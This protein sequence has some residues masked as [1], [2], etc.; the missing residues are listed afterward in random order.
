MKR[1]FKLAL[2]SVAVAIFGLAACTEDP[3]NGGGGGDDIITNPIKD[4]SLSVKINSVSING[5][6]GAIVTE[7]LNEVAYVV[8]PTAEAKEYTAE[9]LFEQGT[10]IEVQQEDGTGAARLNIE[11]LAD[12]TEYTLQMAGRL[13]QE[14]EEEGGAENIYTF[15]SIAKATFTT[16]IR[17][18]MKAEIIEGSQT[19]NSAKLKVTTA[20]ISRF[21]YKVFTAEEVAAESFVAP[22]PAIIFAEGTLLSDIAMGDTE[23]H[24]THL[25]ANTEYVVYIAGE[26]AET[27]NFYEE[28]LKVE[29]I[30]TT[31]FA[32]NIRVYDITYNTF[33][34]DVKAPTTLGNH[35]IKWATCDLYTYNTNI[36]YGSLGGRPTSMAEA[37]NLNDGAFGN[38]FNKSTTLTFS[39]ENSYKEYDGDI[40][41]YYMSLVPGQP[42]VVML[43]E[44]RWGES[45]WGWG[46][47][48]YI[49][50]FDSDYYVTELDL[51]RTEEDMLT[52]ARNQGKYWD[53]GAFFH[54]LDVQLQ[55]PELLTKKIDVNIET[56]PDGAAI[57]ITPEEGIDNFIVYIENQEMHSVLVNML[58]GEEGYNKHIQW[59]ITSYTG[60]LEGAT[61]FTRKE[62]YPE[63]T[64]RLELDDFF[65]EHAITREDIYR[66]HVVGLDDDDQS[67][68][69]MDGHIQNYASYEFQLKEA[70]E[71]EPTF[72][73][74]F[75][76]E[77]ST[78]TKAVFNLRCT[79]TATSKAK[80]AYY[81]ANSERA[82][83]QVTGSCQALLDS[84]GAPLEGTDVDAI[85]SPEGLNIPIATFPNERI[86]MAAKISNADGTR[87]Y[88]SEPVISDIAMQ[89]PSSLDISALNALAGDW[90]ATATIGYD[91]KQTDESGNFIQD[92]DGNYVT[93]WKEEQVQC[94]I[95]IGGNQTYPET[96]PE[97]VIKIF[98]DA[99]VSRENALAYFEEFKVAVD[100]YN[101]NLRNNNQIICKGWGFDTTG[102][103]QST[104]ADAYELFSSADYGGAYTL[105]PIFDFG[106]KWSIQTDGTNFWVPFNTNTY[107][108]L[109]S[110][111]STKTAFGNIW[112]EYHLIGNSGKSTRAYGDIDESF[113]WFETG[114]YADGRF[115]VEISNGGNTL[116]IKPVDIEVISYKLSDDGLSYIESGREVQTFYPCA[117]HNQDNSGSFYFASRIVS[118]IVLTRG[119]T[120]PATPAV[121]K[122]AV[123][124]NARKRVVREVESHQ[125][126]RTVDVPRTRTSFEGEG[127]K[128]YEYPVIGVEEFHRR[129]IKY[130]NSLRGNK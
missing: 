107:F 17:P 74:T 20:N 13:V 117:G 93:K 116:T 29:G 3:N 112:N 60:M 59:W 55:K 69:F 52:I 11:E 123:M 63:G 124:K 110:H 68:G 26:L 101:Q 65:Y 127:V 49:P 15:E 92:T 130:L 114:Y 23:L 9:E 75:V 21:G 5:A 111:T 16:S 86:Y 12:N 66:L 90:T 39:E 89:N 37:M 35:V 102:Y 58:D 73:L 43:G 41:T 8:E 125:E 84:Y 72:E 106:P 4:A 32:E 34:V 71:P 47:G 95:T 18:V 14:P 31:D 82:W 57:S 1:F 122:A 83:H 109:S 70:T 28:V 62:N 87:V 51:A 80:K 126:I 115:P 2:W 103:I 105:A 85:N 33:N 78:A 77:Q 104:Y 54:K 120:E 24:I 25:A 76:P 46:Y 97:D 108:P 119:Y 100:A 6:K 19:A 67:D 79:S 10:I 44:F 88:S 38:Y 45:L 113:K 56:R 61:P 129:N 128:T 121:A 22:S 94:K 118:D 98:E 36:I 48:Y 30:K 81:V 50:L 42:Q 27:E 64:V 99:K 40:L 7:I 53:E 96:L 91:E